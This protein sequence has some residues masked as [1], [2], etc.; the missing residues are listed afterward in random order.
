M[1]N[2]P[3]FS[4]PDRMCLPPDLDV[5]AIT[6][7]DMAVAGPK[8][9]MVYERPKAAE[10]PKNKP[11]RLKVIAPLTVGLAALVAMAALTE[12]GRNI[13]H[14]ALRVG[15]NLLDNAFYEQD[16][17]SKRYTQVSYE[18]KPTDSQDTLRAMVGNDPMAWDY[19]VIANGNPKNFEAGRKIKVPI[20]AKEGQTLRELFADLKR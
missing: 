1:Y 5:Q 17:S 18:I 3:S 4:T 19:I 13:S 14:K 15:G 10:I 11:N 20:P 9:L 2:K 7:R 16:V 12:T 8:G 6:P